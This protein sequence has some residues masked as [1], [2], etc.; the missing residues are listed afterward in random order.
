MA[1]VSVA[2]HA[3]QIAGERLAENECVRRRDN[4]ANFVKCAHP[5]SP[6]RRPSAGRWLIRQEGQRSGRLDWNTCKEYFSIVM[7]TILF[8][9]LN[10]N[11]A[12][13]KWDA[14]QR[15][16]KFSTFGQYIV[17]AMLTFKKKFTRIPLMH[18][19]NESID[20]VAPTRMADA[21]GWE[22]E[23]AREIP[24]HSLCDFKHLSTPQ[25]WEM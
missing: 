16:I 13:Q 18:P 11:G 7:R 1:L 8:I 2:R 23:E 24:E 17:L 15:F 14:F 20:V 3:F 10:Q 5:M 9:L 21:E 22:R 4:C 12:V 19:Q 6:N 25:R